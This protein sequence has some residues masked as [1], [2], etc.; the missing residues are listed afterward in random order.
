MTTGEHTGARPPGVSAVMSHYLG[1]LYR[2]G[3]NEAVVSPSELAEVMDVTPPAAARMIERLEEKDLVK[4]IPYQ[5]VRLTTSGTKEALREIRYHR[6][7]EAF[8]VRVMEYGWHE[9]HDMADALAEVADAEFVRRM[10]E[11]AG[12]PSR[13]PHGEP[14]PTA[15]GEMPLVEDV[16]LSELPVGSEGVISRVKVREE[17]KLVYLAE[18]GIVP[19]EPFRIEGKAPFGGPVRVSIRRGE[20]TLGAELAANVRVE[21]APPNGDSQA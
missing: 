13:C 8:L 3:G 18:V 4:R 9:A 20:Q 15:E 12:F 17:D 6:L 2:L 10:D 11:K 1:E 21:V 7:S 19:Q 16:P 14:I 5:G